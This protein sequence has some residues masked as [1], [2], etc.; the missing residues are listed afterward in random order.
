MAIF[1]PQYS[2]V[3]SCLH[4]TTLAG[5]ADNSSKKC[6]PYSNISLKATDVRLF[7]E[8]RLASNPVSGGTLEIW[9]TSSVDGFEY[10]DGYVYNALPSTNISNPR[11]SRHL[12]SIPAIDSIVTWEGA[13]LDYIPSI[14]AHF[15][16]V[17]W[18]RTGAALH[19]SIA[20][21]LNAVMVGFEYA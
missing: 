15:A 3:Y 17:L 1:I 10:T 13:V 2:S 18:N 16:F 21:R 7:L 9:M 14:P 20:S 5:L 12:V 4:N 8:A 6:V 19:A 11:Y